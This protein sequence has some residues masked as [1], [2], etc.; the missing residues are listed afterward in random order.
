[1]KYGIYVGLL[2][3]GVAIGYLFGVNSVSE[4]VLD[5]SDTT[6]SIATQLIYDT[7][8][9]KKIIE[10]P[11]TIESNIDTLTD[12]ILVDSLLTEL[13]LDSLEE[14]FLEKP[15]DTV[16]DDGVKINTDK[17]IAS[18]KVNIIY[19]EKSVLED[20]LIKTALNITEVKSGKIII[21]FWESPINYSGYKLSKSKLIVYGLSPQFE[22]KLYKRETLYYLNF[23]SIYY[24]LI[25][26]NQ[27]LSYKLI[28][29]SDVFNN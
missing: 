15:S 21:E 20:S 2:V 3:V 11:V 25:E 19:L 27:F 14:T 23:Q 22:Y 16:T 10:V 12:T 28:D 1:M 9:T 4:K 29:Q 8:V 26:T 5:E 13:V 24:E 18:T 17:K 7:V 6:S